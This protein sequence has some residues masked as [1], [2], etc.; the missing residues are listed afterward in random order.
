MNKGIWLSDVEIKAL[1]TTG[2]AW[3]VVKAA[4]DQATGAADLTDQESD[5]NVKCLAAALVYARTGDSKALG[6]VKAAL[7]KVAGGLPL[8]RAL[9][10]GRELCAYVLSADLIDLASVDS[11]L[12]GK[13]RTEIKRLLTAPTSGG[14]ANLTK[15]HEDRP[16]NW[17]CHAGA[18]RIAVALY[19]GDKAELD[20]AAQVFRG[21]TG[22]RSA[23]AGFKYTA[24]LDWQADPSKPVGVNPKGAMIQGHNVDGMLPD[25]IRR[26][27]AFKWPPSGAK[28]QM[29]SWEG[30]QGAVVQAQLLSRAGYD[31]WN[32]SD[33]AI[34]RAA[35]FLYNI[36]W[37]A[38]GD[39][40]WQPW[41]INAAYGTNFPTNEAA[42][43]GKNMGYTQWTHAKQGS[44]PPVPDPTPT[45]TPDCA[46]C[47]A[48]LAKVKAQLQQVVDLVQSWQGE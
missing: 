10:L 21:W 44:K 33:K 28:A 6:N 8:G 18:S 14:P 13:F 47:L 23:Y 19:L 38:Q 41:L 43:P 5:A 30:L 22:D 34:L 20:R 16:N 25:D 9:A 37:T 1:P 11:A 40:G 46:A 42:T 27:G 26:S 24:P 7:A 39:D 3:D 48:E 36:G 12:D 45:P 31:A 32:W 17:G 29:Y 15:C 35:Q 2:K 4:A